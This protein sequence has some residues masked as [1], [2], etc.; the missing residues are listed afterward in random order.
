MGWW[1]VFM[2]AAQRHYLILD[3]RKLSFTVLIFNR[4]YLKIPLFL[5][6][7]VSLACFGQKQ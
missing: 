6:A 2:K 5:A 3:V 1:L 4:V 7:P